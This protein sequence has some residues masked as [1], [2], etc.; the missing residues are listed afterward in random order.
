M[1]KVSS[2]LCRSVLAAVAVLAIL[3]AAAGAAPGDATD[4]VVHVHSG[5]GAIVTLNVSAGSPMTA[6]Q[7]ADS[8]GDTTFFGT[9]PVGSQASATATLDGTTY[10]GKVITLTSNNN[11]INLFT[12]TVTAVPEFGTIAG[13]S[14]LLLGAMAFI[15]IRRRRLVAAR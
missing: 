2:F 7:T 13:A 5:P 11:T 4:V 12:V 14:A 8:K 10:Q 9:W 15:F 1:R 3:A 6:T